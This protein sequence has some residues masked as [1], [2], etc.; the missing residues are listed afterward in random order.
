MAEKVKKRSV[1]IYDK[2]QKFPKN[3]IQQKH[4]QQISEKKIEVQIVDINIREQILSVKH[5]VIV[6]AFSCVGVSF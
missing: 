5:R 6:F 3:I 2:K 1:Q 4:Y